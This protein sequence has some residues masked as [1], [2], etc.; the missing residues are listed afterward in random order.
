MN[1]SR[2]VTSFAR[3][4]PYIPRRIRSEASRAWLSARNRW[5][6][7]P[8]TGDA[9]VLVSLT[10]YGPRHATVHLAI[11]SIARGSVRPRELVL[12]VDDPVLLAAP[13]PGIARLISRGLQVRSTSDYG[14][15]KKYFPALPDVVAGGFT[16]LVTADDDSLYPRRWLYGLVKVGS[17]SPNDI[18]CYRARRVTFN[19]DDLAAWQAWPLCDDE[20]ASFLNLAIGDAGVAY[21][22]TFLPSLIDRG[23]EFLNT[24]PRADDLWLHSTAL[25]GGVKTRQVASRALRQLVIPGTQSVG[26]ARTN[27]GLSENDKQL[28]ATHRCEELEVLRGEAS[29]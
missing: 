15:H 19:G 4:L 29:K 9:N 25:R 26:L 18:V 5:S 21:P 13:T 14:P 6:R 2:R 3:R 27:I 11:E 20:Q 10:T 22:R 12:W 28:R 1:V 8:V 7:S 17:A 24:A 23:E 16:H